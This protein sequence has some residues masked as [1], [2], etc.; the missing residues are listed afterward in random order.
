VRGLGAGG[1]G[2]GGAGHR[3]GGD[4]REAR[5][6]LLLAETCGGARQLLG[7]LGVLD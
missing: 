2:L 7:R 5:V 6:N 1:L 4:A 3:V